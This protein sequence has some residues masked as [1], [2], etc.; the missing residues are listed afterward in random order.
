ML[1]AG[2][3]VIVIAIIYIFFSR[4]RNNPQVSDAR[5]VEIVNNMRAMHARLKEKE[6]EVYGLK[7]K[8]Y[9]DIE[10]IRATDQ[11]MNNKIMHFH[12]EAFV[13]L[14]ENNISG[15]R[16]FVKN[17]I[18]LKRKT[19]SLRDLQDLIKKTDNLIHQIL[20][21]QESLKIQKEE[22]VALS[23][24]RDI[25]TEDNPYYMILET[26]QVIDTELEQL[27]EKIMNLRDEKARIEAYSVRVEED[28]VEEEL[29]R[30][31]NEIES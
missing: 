15:A 18:A 30:L 10:S 24:K 13:A 14:R 28:A 19:E 7:E 1:L 4:R 25:A 11:N 31:E 16:T 22:V 5:A 9:D 21:H 26:L 23:R 12:Q 27:D 17:K 6:K 2:A 20:N 29:I 8:I 3:F